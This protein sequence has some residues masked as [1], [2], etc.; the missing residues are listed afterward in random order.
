M[1]PQHGA[2]QHSRRNESGYASVVAVSTGLAGSSG[3]TVKWSFVV[4]PSGGS[5]AALVVV[6]LTD[7]ADQ[8]VASNGM[9]FRR[10]NGVTHVKKPILVVS[11]VPKGAS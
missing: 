1:T 11:R 8:V 4:P 2:C 7:E 9:R 10:P 6:R 5:A 3:S